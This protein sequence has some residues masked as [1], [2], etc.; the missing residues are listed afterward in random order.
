MAL[1]LFLSRPLSQKADVALFL[2]LNLYGARPYLEPNVRLSSRGRDVTFAPGQTHI[3][4][5]LS[6]AEDNVPYSTGR[7]FIE[8]LTFSD[9][10]FIKV[11]NQASFFYEDDDTPRLVLLANGSV[12]REGTPASE[13]LLSVETNLRNLDGSAAN[14]AITLRSSRPDVV[15]VPSAT[16]KVSALR[17]GVFPLQVLE[18]AGVNAPTPVTLTASGPG[19]PATSATIVVVEREAPGLSVRFAP[20]VIDEDSL[21]PATGTVTRSG[22]T[23]Q[24]LIVALSNSNPRLVSLPS[25]VT[26]PMGS[27]SASFAV[28]PIEARVVDATDELGVDARQRRLQAFV[29]ASFGRLAS[30]RARLDVRDTT[31]II[32]VVATPS[33]MNEEDAPHGVLTLRLVRPRAHDVTVKI[34][35]LDSRLLLAGARNTIAWATLPRDGSKVGVRFSILN[36]SGTQSGAESPII[37][38]DG[39]ENPYAPNVADAFVYI[40]IF[41]D[42]APLQ[43]RLSRGEVTT[44]NLAS[45]VEVTVRR[46]QPSAAA[47]AVRLSAQASFRDGHASLLLPPIVTIPAGEQSVTVTAKVSASSEQARGYFDLQ[48][49]AGGDSAQDSFLVHSSKALGMVT[50]QDRETLSASS[51]VGSVTLRR[52]TFDT[53]ATLLIEPVAASASES[54]LVSAPARVLMPAGQRFVSVPL[55]LLRDPASDTTAQFALSIE[56]AGTSL[57]DERL[58]VAVRAD[59]PAR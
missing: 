44:S 42:D 16:L 50:Q 55:R 39:F 54:G 45:S 37:I 23:S 21:T 15:R 6:A 8:T 58:L 32:E 29:A 24:A 47:L 57:G 41:D 48:A 5:V 19:L 56:G 43:L 20:S 12:W 26:I 11:K 7:I 59:P 2:S 46:R 22:P 17:S 1:D 31:P 34:D 28:Q 52:Q 9:E 3:S 25:S 35:P 53:T 30:G 49:R 40:A 4:L 27:R 14:A 33:R 13:P 18:R 10:P 36:H 38:S 51:P